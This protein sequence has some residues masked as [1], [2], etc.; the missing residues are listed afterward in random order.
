MQ[1]HTKIVATLG[2]ASSDAETLER[3]IAA[4]VD[5]VRMN[6]S[7]GKPED[8]INRAKLVRDAAAK[9]GRTVGILG[10]LQGPK[11]RVGKFGI[12][13]KVGYIS[14]GGGAFLEFL[15]GKVLPAVDAL[16]KRANG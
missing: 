10:D 14:T 16:S 8:H 15:E 1:R 7:H 5:V 13:D 11:I 4:G 12:A 9:V 3:M 6:F 2:P